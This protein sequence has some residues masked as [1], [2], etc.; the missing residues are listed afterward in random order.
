MFNKKTLLLFPRS[1]GAKR[2]VFCLEKKIK[3]E[4]KT[5]NNRSFAWQSNY[6]DRIFRNEIE[7]QR[8]SRYIQNNHIKRYRDRDNDLN[9]CM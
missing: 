4:A 1:A 6:Y 8:I 9:I 7:L 3:A 5:M 2:G